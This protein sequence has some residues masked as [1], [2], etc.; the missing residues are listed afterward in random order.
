MLDFIQPG[1]DTRASDSRVPLG[2]PRDNEV[3][4]GIIKL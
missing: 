3:L 1:D 4:S 2:W